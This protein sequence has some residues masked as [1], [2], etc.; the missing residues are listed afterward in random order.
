MTLS[1]QPS[2]QCWKIKLLRIG[3]QIL[4]L[5][6]YQRRYQTTT[7]KV[8]AILQDAVP[9]NIIGMLTLTLKGQRNSSSHPTSQCK[10]SQILHQHA[11]PL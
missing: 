1:Q 6:T 11:K 3:D 9:H 8:N 2:S 4:R 10:A 5:H 7:T